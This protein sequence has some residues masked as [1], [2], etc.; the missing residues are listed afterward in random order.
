M[1]DF[2]GDLVQEQP[3]SKDVQKVLK[4][5]RNHLESQECYCPDQPCMSSNFMTLVT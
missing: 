3:K 1:E 5:L 4:A 2:N